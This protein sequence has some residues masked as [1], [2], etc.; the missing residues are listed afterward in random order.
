MRRFAAREAREE[1]EDLRLHRDVER[2]CRLVQQQDRRLKDQRAARWRRAAA[3]RPTA[4]A[5]SGERKSRIQPDIGRAPCRSAPR[6][7]RGRGCGSAR[8][9]PFGRIA[10]DAASHRGPGRPSAYR[11]QNALRGI[12]VTDRSVKPDRAGPVSTAVPAM[13]RR[14]VDLPEPDSPTSPKLSPDA[15]RTPTPSRIFRDPSVMETSSSLMSDMC[16]SSASPQPGRI[17]LQHRQAA[18][19]G[20]RCWGSAASSPRE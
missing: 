18:G 1:I 5:D 14:I 15:T 10:A 4:R 13:H 12:S 16:V 2:R 20:R 6:R 9:R 8:A 19:V 7:G 11:R 3:A 17:A